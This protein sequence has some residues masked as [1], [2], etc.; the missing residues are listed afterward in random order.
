[1]TY[2]RRSILV[3]EDNEATRTAL[4]RLFLLLKA[5]RVTAV[6]TVAEGLAALESQPPDCI[7]AD[8]NL[9]DGD[10]GHVLEEAM[11]RGLP[12]KRV[13]ATATPYGARVRELRATCADAVLAKPIDL[14]ELAD[15]LVAQ[16]G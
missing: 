12:A 10:G 7:L 11:R 15:A 2:S 1:M 8:L 4:V 3:V 5:E 14:V 6:A 13:L 16:I 9:P